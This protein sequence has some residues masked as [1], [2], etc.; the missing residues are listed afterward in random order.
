MKTDWRRR[1]NK[2]TS[3]WLNL[4]RLPI[5]RVP[6]GPFKQSGGVAP[7]APPRA[8][9]QPRGPGLRERTE[10]SGFR[11]FPLLLSSEPSLLLL[12]P[13][14]RRAGVSV[15]YL[16]PR[17]RGAGMHCSYC[18]SSSWRPNGWRFPAASWTISAGT[19]PSRP[20]SASPVPQSPTPEASQSLLRAVVQVLAFLCRL[21]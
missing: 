16:G 11:P 2:Q 10:V 8:S 3:H 5:H 15:L 17:P 19:A 13:A 14:V 20:P 7:G 18:G 12:P 21:C 6:I 4:R 1:T 9:T